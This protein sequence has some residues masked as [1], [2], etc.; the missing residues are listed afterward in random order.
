MDRER[1]S[2]VWG[3]AYERAF[4][5]AKGLPLLVRLT[6]VTLFYVAYKQLRY[7]TEG[8]RNAKKTS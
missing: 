3:R 5:D 1:S 6:P 8:S 4:A 7:A 2:A